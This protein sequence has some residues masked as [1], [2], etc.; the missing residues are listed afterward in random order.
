V[1]FIRVLIR[2]FTRILLFWPVTHANITAFWVLQEA[3]LAV[4]HAHDGAAA[5]LLSSEDEDAAVGLIRR[6][7]AFTHL[8]ACRR[9]QEPMRAVHEASGVTAT[10]LYSQVTRR[11]QTKAGV[12]TIWIL[13]KPIG[14]E[15]VAGLNRAG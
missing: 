8:T 9:L 4:H 2:I 7:V 12:A 3:M 5:V 15:H 11:R 13:H 14:T 10:R 1:I 6:P